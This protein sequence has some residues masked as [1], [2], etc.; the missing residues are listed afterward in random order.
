MH[1]DSFTTEEQSNIIYDYVKWYRHVQII[2]SMNE[3]HANMSSQ[4]RTLIHQ[5]KISLYKK[6]S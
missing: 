2:M 1:D 5:K 6:K 3:K 4:R